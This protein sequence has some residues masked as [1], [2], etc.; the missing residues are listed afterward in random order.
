M[1]NL[2]RD[3]SA[4]AGLTT[5]VRHAVRAV[6]EHGWD[7]VLEAVSDQVSGGGRAAPPGVI[8]DLWAAAEKVS[9]SPLTPVLAPLLTAFLTTAGPR[10]EETA[11][12]ARP[13]HDELRIPDAEHLGGP[14][15]RARQR[16]FLA[17]LASAQAAAAVAAASGASP[18][19]TAFG[20]GIAVPG[21]GF[22][23]TGAPARGTL[24]VVLFC[25]ALLLWFGTGNMA[26]P[27]LVWVGAAT[28]AARHAHRNGLRWRSAG[29]AIAA[30]TGA[31]ALQIRRHRRAVLTQQRSQAEAA[32]EFLGVAERPLADRSPD[33]PVVEELDDEQLAL[34]RRF[35]DMALQEPDDWSDW[36]VID[37]FQPA[38]LRYQINAVQD[39][40][41]V[42]RYTRNPAF[43]GYLHDAHTRLFDR[44]LQR[45]VWGYWAWE[46]LWGN[47]E[48]DPD[49]ARRQ[50]I[51]MT[52]YLAQS[53]GLYQAV[54]G[55]LRHSSPGALTFVWNKRRKF[56][57]DYN[58]LCS[59]LA[60]DYVRSPW[61]LVVCE[62]NWIFSL[63]NMRG[64]TGLRLH[65]QIHGTNYWAQVE[66]GYRRGFQRE[67]VRPD[68]MV[69]GHR[70][71][72]VGFGAPG[73]SLSADLRPLVPN[74]ADRGFLLLQS[75]CRDADGNVATP[76]K[77][78]D[79]LL[80]PGNYSFN[81]LAAY[82]MVIDEA[83]EAGD[84]EL[85]RG[86]DAELRER[87][88]LAVDDR[89]WLVAEGA[90]ILAHA[91]YA[92]GSWGRK[93]GWLDLVEKG[94][95]QTW[96]DGPYLEHVDYPDVMVARSES[97]DGQRL[98]A[99]LRSQTGRPTKVAVAG[100]RPGGRYEVTGCAAQE[101]VADSAGRAQLEVTGH[102][103]L[104]LDLAPTRTEGER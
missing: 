98:S 97:I 47:L 10:A 84:E 63:C 45:K 5:A 40:L 16:R 99:V 31:T 20:A 41:A 67:L 61:G 42:Q 26:A 69:M 1:I 48:W 28:L 25:V 51:M 66:D 57:Y 23:A 72:R 30:V 29:I 53:L 19:T 104:A 8:A 103:R 14:L 13:P 34:T 21:G 36:N 12:D 95:P 6:D 68:G 22:L 37:Q 87:L 52:G 90:S 24:T 89:G 64:G 55:D 76:F 27:G 33:I 80:D 15:S 86:V 58:S 96:R 78:D 49:P 77:H 88:P 71:S 17:V 62:P 4:P 82:G 81:P 9:A 39:A 56:E 60:A 101:L 32:N 50:N 100:L 35:V 75:I 83:R 91:G 73:L 3:G 94:R 70:S 102:G 59:H 18:A 44:Y 11:A 65:D 2:M 79:K 43:T 93:A 74:V 7:A 46:N 38:A 85:A 54:S 92:R